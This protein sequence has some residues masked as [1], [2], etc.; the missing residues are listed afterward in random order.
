[1]IENSL[2]S[3]AKVEIVKL[4]QMLKEGVKDLTMPSTYIDS[5]WHEM[6]DRPEYQPFCMR[7][8]AMNVI[9]DPASGEGE[10]K[11]VKEYEKRFGKLP[12]VWFMNRDGV[13]D[14]V[15]FEAYNKTG[16]WEKAKWDCIPK[17]DD[18][19]DGDKD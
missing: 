16:R 1:M 3:T 4:F 2:E 14:F 13:V 7:H 15:S 6:I 10:I 17:E 5:V 9:H 12:Q 19:G 8:A 11:W 18:Y